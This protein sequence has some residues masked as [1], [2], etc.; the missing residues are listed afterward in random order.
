MGIYRKINPSPEPRIYLVLYTL[1]IGNRTLCPIIFLFKSS[2]R[3]NLIFIHFFVSTSILKINKLVFS[4]QRIF[5]Q[6]YRHFRKLTLI[7]QMFYKGF[8]T[9]LTD[10]TGEGK[11]DE[12]SV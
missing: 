3:K 10:G 9:S 1:I 6:N 11:R 7:K 4:A 12:T 2:R 5:L 8:Y